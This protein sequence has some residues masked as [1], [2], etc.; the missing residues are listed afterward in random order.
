MFQ[1]DINPK[2]HINTDCGMDK[3]GQQLDQHKSWP[4]A[5][6]K[7]RPEPGNA[8]MKLNSTNIQSKLSQKL[9]D[10]V[11]NRLVRVTITEGLFYQ[12]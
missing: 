7:V 10:G 1:Q 12:I 5:C 4:Q 2:T 3:A 8:Q 9:V 11:Q 6:R